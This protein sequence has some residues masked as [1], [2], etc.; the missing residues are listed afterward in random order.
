MGAALGNYGLQVFM[1]D[2]QRATSID[3]V[4]SENILNVF[5]VV[6]APELAFQEELAG[7][8]GPI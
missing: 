1:S 6:A 4:V 2:R 5:T 3:F 8:A 7:F